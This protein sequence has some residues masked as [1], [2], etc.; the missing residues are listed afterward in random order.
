[1]RTRAG[2]IG[3]A[4]LI[5]IPCFGCGSGSGPGA[6]TMVPVKGKVT[7]KGQPVTT[8]TVVF[9]PDDGGREAH[10]DVKSD[11]TFVLTTFK[12]SDGAHPGTHRVAVT[13]A[14]KVGK[15][16]FPVKYRNP[17][18]SKTLVDVVEGTNEYAVD[19]K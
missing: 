14:F 18:S 4:A 19:F 5:F 1:M 13:G 7:Y 9:E 10:G 12:D 16:T 11:G 6:G 8:G 15:V 2:S 3:L 17:S